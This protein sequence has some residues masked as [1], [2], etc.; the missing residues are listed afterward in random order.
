MTPWRVFLS[1][2]SDLRSLPSERSFVAAAEEAVHLLGEVAEEMGRFPAEDRAPAE[3]CRARVFRCDLY[4]AIVGFKYG[5]EVPDQPDLSY[6]E[7]EFAAA[8]ERG[9]PRLVFLLDPE[10]TVGPRGLLVDN[11]FGTRQ[12]A[13]RE[14]LTNDS[15]LTVRVVSSPSELTT[16]L[17]LAVYQLRNELRETAGTADPVSWLPP[18][19]ESP[20]ER[21]DLTR[22][23]AGALWE[24]AADEG[25][26]AAPAGM[27]RVTVL[28]GDGGTGKT[29]VAAM[30]AY[31]SAAARAY[32]DG[33]MSVTIGRGLT[34]AR[35]AAKVND[36]S[37]RLGDTRPGP[38]DPGQAGMRLGE[39]LGRRR[40]LLIIDDVWEAAQLAPFLHGG[41]R[42]HRLVTARDARVLPP[43]ATVIEVD[44]MTTAQATR[45]LTDANPALDAGAARELAQLTGRYPL[46]LSLVAGDLRTRTG[47]GVSAA[48]AAAE[49]AEGLREVGVTAFDDGDLSRAV[50]DR[51][52]ASLRLLRDDS[53]DGGEIA[54]YQ[55][56]AIFAQ[57]SAIPM[58]VIER[59]WGHTAGWTAW[60]TQRLIGRLAQLSLLR[61]N[62]RDWPSVRLHDVIRDYLRRRI[63]PAMLPALHARLLD[64]CRP[65]Q[66]ADGG[67]SEAGTAPETAAWWTLPPAATYLWTNLCFH[68]KEAGRDEELTRLTHDLR[69][70]AAKIIAVGPEGV[71]ADMALLPADGQARAL[72]RLVRQIGHLPRREDPANRVTAI[73]ASY[74]AGV[75]VL[76]G[77]AAALAS[78]LAEPTLLPAPP[79]LPDQPDPALRRTFDP[80]M[81]AP[82]A[83]A[84]APDGSWLAVAGGGT[85]PS[86]LGSVHLWDPVAGTD[87]ATFI[88]GP[89]AISALAPAAGGA[90]LVCGS[91]AGSLSI[92]DVGDRVILACDGGHAGRVTALASAPDGSWIASGGEDGLIKLWNPPDAGARGVL[93]GQDWV[94]VLV[95]APDGS[96][97]ASAHGDGA[98][99]V[100]DI[101]SGSRAVELRAASGLVSAL[102]VGPAGDWLAAAGVDGTRRVWSTRDWSLLSVTDTRGGGRAVLAAAVDG[103]WLATA[104]GPTIW[105]TD[106]VDWSQ[107]AHL[108]GPAAGVTAMA[109]APDGD[110]LAAAYGDGVVRVWEPR[111]SQLRNELAG[112]SS[113]I[114]ALVAA[115]DG[116][117]L[118]T[119]GPGTVRVWHPTATGESRRRAEL[120][121][122][123]VALAAPGHGRWAVTAG[124]DGVVRLRSRPPARPVDPREPGSSEP[125]RRAVARLTTRVTDTGQPVLALDP[126]G[127]WFAA[128]GLDAPVRIWPV[129]PGP[130][131]QD[132]VGEP[133][134]LPSSPAGVTALAAAP[135]GSWLAAGAAE[136]TVR[137]WDLRSVHGRPGTERG[138]QSADPRVLTGQVGGIASL[139]VAPDGSWLAAAGVDAT[140]RIW[141]TADPAA[142]SRTLAGH[143]RAVVGLLP[144]PDGSWLASA[145]W[146]GTVRLWDPLGGGALAILSGHTDAVHALAVS[147]DSRLLLTGGRDR[148]LNVW[149]LSRVLP[150][151]GHAGRGGAAAGPAGPSEVRASGV[152]SSIRLD[153]P[154]RCAVWLDPHGHLLVGGVRG[155]Y[156]LRLGAGAGTAQ[157]WPPGPRPA[158]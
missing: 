42:C 157:G 119:A 38:A 156:R 94:S 54:R 13:F 36:L 67:G 151:P 83:L 133:Y 6:T 113:G 132:A 95:A 88:L 138:G 152:A 72:R 126:G 65:T 59:L 142:P 86:G 116:R 122:S 141:R 80:P 52:E 120:T 110:W 32:P 69:W 124:G 56:L 41:P 104:N 70:A 97:L 131:G 103:S 47:L 100:W 62:P 153:G 127:R 146:D 14:R 61:A 143:T 51:I 5:S 2:T 53:A 96:W 40:L 136:A 81:P 106:P 26:S 35:L 144:A 89:G 63:G 75:D 155:L 68:M 91:G 11:V 43:Y 50:G 150:P 49:A 24:D 45:M 33:V 118:A 9:M 55:E 148:L 17:V 7:L 76:R 21:P 44:M 10:R 19:D 37:I 18:M 87:R 129:D 28:H 29:T 77:P 125:G 20:V 64:A 34:D 134:A 15:S 90:L 102:A 1:H 58:T 111:T 130:D 8:T 121:G 23:L 74:A 139:A 22:Q 99:R 145:S 117:W 66:P 101:A 46:L 57:G 105:I 71:E 114:V 109:G 84:V 112:H 115:P 78:T 149:D 135:D 140:I 108:D 158:G 154:V 93:A 48:Q 128:A 25:G 31:G 39:L 27:G 60:R 137:L 98:V 73:I 30:V 123:V 79:P 85:V 82:A 107:T 3:V 92:V 147:P 4:V 16:Q 12:E